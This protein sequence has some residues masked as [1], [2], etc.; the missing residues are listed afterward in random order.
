MRISSLLVAAALLPFSLAVRTEISQRRHNLRSNEQHTQQRHLE[1][2]EYRLMRAPKIISNM[3]KTRIGSRMVDRD[4]ITVKVSD[5][6]TIGVTVD[7]NVGVD[8]S[9][10]SDKSDETG[11]PECIEWETFYI[12]VPSKSSKSSSSKSMKGSKGGKS[13]K[14]AGKSTKMI[15]VQECIAYA[16]NDPTKE[17]T[18]EPVP[19]ETPSPTDEEQMSTSSVSDNDA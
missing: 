18:A 19:I 17:P 5:D 6:G 1:I 12:P 2:D 8:V 7:V 11:E 14:S 15:P 10:D 3:Q 9:T 4:G 13:S 16:T